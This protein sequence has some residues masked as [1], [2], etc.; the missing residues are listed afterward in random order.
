MFVFSGS[1]AVFVK[2]PGSVGNHHLVTPNQELLKG[3]GV[4]LKRKF[5]CVET[6]RP[7]RLNHLLA[8]SSMW[9]TGGSVSDLREGRPGWGDG[10]WVL[11][12]PP[13]LFNRFRATQ[14]LSLHTSGR[15]L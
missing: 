14:T 12:A 2:F 7:K 10:S 5:N 15:V 4:P 6:V 1:K 13:G 11:G 9:L 3:V 8:V